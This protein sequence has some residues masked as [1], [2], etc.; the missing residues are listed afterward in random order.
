MLVNRIVNEL[1]S[2]STA[3]HLM[4]LSRQSMSY[5]NIHEHLRLATLVRPALR[6]VGLRDGDRR[7]GGSEREEDGGGVHLDVKGVGV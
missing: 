3:C 2:V 1:G 4:L 7:H 6:G 5:M